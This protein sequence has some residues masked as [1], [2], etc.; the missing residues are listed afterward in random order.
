MDFPVRELEVGDLVDE[1]GTTVVLRK[2]HIDLDGFGFSSGERAEL[3]LH[4]S[5]RDRFLSIW[6]RCRSFRLPWWRRQRL[7]LRLFLLLIGN[8][9]MTLLLR[10]SSTLL[11]EFD[12][13]RSTLFRPPVG[14]FVLDSPLVLPVVEELLLVVVVLLDSGSACHD[15]DATA[16]H[17]VVDYLRLNVLRNRIKFA[18]SSSEP[19]PCCSFPFR[20]D[21]R[22]HHRL[23]LAA[24]VGRRGVNRFNR[25]HRLGARCHRLA[26]VKVQLHSYEKGRM[27]HWETRGSIWLH[28]GTGK[29]SGWGPSP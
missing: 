15:I 22:L 1:H 8:D 21:Q 4:G 5:H 29:S 20:H 12:V 2:T 9:E 6:L 16:V 28:A 14:E 23:V 13:L 18:R 11:N 25:F 24:A 26:V 19:T 3:V 10:G 7:G 27:T 17:D